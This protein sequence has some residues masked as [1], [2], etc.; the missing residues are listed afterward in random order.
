MRNR[1]WVIIAVLALVLGRSYAAAASYEAVS[2]EILVKFLPTTAQDTIDALAG[3][4][5]GRVTLTFRGD[6]DLRLVRIG[7]PNGLD[8]AIAF[9]KSRAEVRYAEPNYIRYIVAI[10]NDPSFNV[11]WGLRNTG[12]SG[13]VVGAD[14]DA[15]GA[16]DIWTGNPA[17]VE[18]SIDTGINMTHPDLAG[19]IWTNPGEV[20]GNS[21][22][23]DGNGFVDDVHGWDF[24]NNDRDPTDDHGH[25]SHTSGT[26]GALGNNSTGVTGVNWGVQLMAVKVCNAGGSCPD[27]AIIGGID[28]AT[29][30]HAFVSNNSYGG[31]PFSQA[32]FDAISRADQ[33]GVLFVA[34]AGN[35][36]GNNDSN[37]FYPASYNLL[38]IIS[39]AATDRFDSR[40][41]FSNYGLTTVDLGAPGV[42]IYSTMLG[43]GYGYLS[44]TS[45]AAPHTT[46]VAALLKG[47]NATLTHYQVR[48]LIMD[49]T[50]PISA[51][52]GLT[53]T[54]GV[55]NAHNT[56]LAA[57]AP[58]PPPGNQ[59]PTANPGGPYRSSSRKP[60]TMN[61]S[62]SRDPD[63]SISFYKW[64]FG[65]GATQMTSSATV[66]HTYAAGGT[67]TV[68][69]VVYDNYNVVSAPATTSAKITGK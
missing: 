22:D 20:A 47:Y 14:I 65:D 2:G 13:G 8:A 40:A 4:A 5:D 56:L 9:F 38:N 55:L 6:P 29:Q 48:S 60:V 26:V 34:A 44:G 33:A 16:W 41:S 25:G 62:V 54:G 12:Q 50:R 11:L 19:N 17:V 15:T 3:A 27:S 21:I 35:N 63:G 49:H 32:A 46:G 10:P 45:M 59:A 52:A 42:D 30:N 57:P 43:V 68:T 69:L 67:Y 23:D 28:Y 64:N 51:L 1:G 36:G 37:P 24:V 39:V 61:G 31:G 66:Q 58:N 53:V 18:A 7:D